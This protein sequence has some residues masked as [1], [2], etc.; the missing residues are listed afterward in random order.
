MTSAAFSRLLASSP[1]G[2]ASFRC[3]R[4]LDRRRAGL[5]DAGDDR[6]VADGHTDAFSADGR[7]GAD[8]EYGADAGLRFGRRGAGGHRRSARI[9]LVTQIVLL[10]ATAFS[11]RQRSPGSWARSRCLRARSCSVRASRSTCRRSRRVSTSLVPRADL[12]R[13]VA[14]G[15]VAFNVARA[16]GPALAGAIAAW[17][18]TGSAFLASALFFVVMIVA[19]RHWKSR[20]RPLPVFRNA[21]VGYPERSA[22]RPPFGRHALADHSQ[23]QF[24]RVCERVLGAASRHRARPARTRRRRVRP[25]LRRVRHR[26]HHRRTGDSASAAKPPV[27]QGRD[28]RSRAVDAGHR[29]RRRRLISPLSRSWA[30]A[31]PAS[32]GS[33]V[34]ASL[35]TGTQS[36]APAWVRARAVAMNIVAVQA[37][38]AIGS[39][40]WGALASAVGTSIALARLRRPDGR[41]ALAE[42]SRARPDGHRGRCD[43]RRAIARHG[44]CVRA[45]AGRWPGPDSGRVSHRAAH[46]KEFLR[47]IHGAEKIRRRNGA[48]SWRVF[49]DLAKTGVLSSV[50]SSLRGRNISAC[51]RA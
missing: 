39:A 15:A 3:L 31:A 48:T 21:A 2:Q 28:V 27:E 8:G 17:S 43:A 4:R 50:T 20:E 13:A 22:L 42:S 30:P 44:D 9:I 10:A 37:S 40:L 49:R 35:S 47:A 34:F 16:V 41:T 26:R 24:R 12:P 33:R 6:G 5:Y 51:V 14:L 19:L 7:V 1:L 32:L 23:L 36:A 25:A 11:A 18:G 38:L 29:P 46:R 45:L